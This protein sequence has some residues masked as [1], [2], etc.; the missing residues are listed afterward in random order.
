MRQSILP[1]GS[2]TPVVFGQSKYSGFGFKT[3]K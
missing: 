1:P 3:L 2:F